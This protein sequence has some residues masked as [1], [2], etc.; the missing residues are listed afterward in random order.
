MGRRKTITIKNDETKLQ[1]GEQPEIN[2]ETE[3]PTKTTS[4]FEFGTSDNSTETKNEDIETTLKE[5]DELVD[6]HAKKDVSDEPTKRG[7]KT[8]EE[9][10][11]TNLKVS[12]YLFAYANDRLA[13]NLISLVDMYAS[14][15]GDFIPAKILQADEKALQ[16]LAPLGEMAAKEMG[17][18]ENPIV[19]FYVLLA[20]NQI[21]NLLQFKSALAQHKKENP[22]FKL[23]DLK[24]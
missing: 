13:S 7:R 3:T 4:T 1:E 22:E 18:E 19:A 2:T 5:L 24:V 15:G 16:E 20:S 10:A 8:K 12:G 21:S 23:S 6:N 17:L 11:K 14:K 9:K